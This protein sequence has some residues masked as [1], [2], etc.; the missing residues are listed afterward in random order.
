MAKLDSN[1][2]LDTV[3]RLEPDIVAIVD[4]AY[5]ASAAISLRRIADSLEKIIDHLD[6]LV[7]NTM[8]RPL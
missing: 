5:Y 7:H 6:T 2:Y 1:D 4:G 8:S 3:A